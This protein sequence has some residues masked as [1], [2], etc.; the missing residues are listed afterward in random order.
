MQE[1]QIYATANETVATVRDFANAKT[2]SAPSF[3]LGV[4]AKIKLTLFAGMNDTLPLAPSELANVVTW[5]FVMDNDFD[6]T[7][8]YKVVADN[9][10]ITWTGASTDGE[11]YPEDPEA[12][13]YDAEHAGEYIPTVF[14]IP[15]PN[16]NST[17]LNE[18][19]GTSASK[20]GLIGE[21][22]GYDSKGANIFVLQIEG[23]SV[24]NRITGSGEPTA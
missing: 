15:L 24:R 2:V 8:D 17:V 19:L 14:T 6:I 1:I 16:M 18:W 23:F 9:A 10:N 21:L 12:E 22:V 4:S 5:S 3:V 7:T 20:S 13:G 11:K